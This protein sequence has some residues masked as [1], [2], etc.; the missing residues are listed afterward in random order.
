M[1]IPLRGEIIFYAFAAVAFL[2]GL[3]ALTPK[4]AFLYSLGLGIVV[5]VVFFFVQ[6]YMEMGGL[7]HVLAP[8]T[9]SMLTCK[10]KLAWLKRKQ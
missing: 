8:A 7:L 2:I 3:F 9:F 6:V 1:P 4:R 10:A 5:C